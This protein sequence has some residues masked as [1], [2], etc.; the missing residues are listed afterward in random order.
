[1]T[2]AR[3]LVFLSAC[4]AAACA[5]AALPCPVVAAPGS[6]PPAVPGAPPAAN[7][8]PAEGVT[9]L[10][11]PAMSPERIVHVELDL[12]P[13][14]QTAGQAAPGPWHLPHGSPSRI[15][16]ASARDVTGELTVATTAKGDG[17]DLVLA[18]P[19]SGAVHVAYDLL[20]G[21]DAPDDPLGALVQDDRFRA[22]GGAMLALPEA[23]ASVSMPVRIRIDG[24]A[25]SAP[26]AASSFGVGNTRRVTMPLGGL[27][28]AVF[29][30]GSLGGQV[31]DDPGAGHDEAA[32]LGYTAFDPRTATAELAQ[33][34]SALH[35]LF[36]EQPGDAWT[37]L[38]VSQT[39]PVGSFS[40]TPRWMSTLLQVG[41]AEPWS[42]ALR[43][44]MTQQLARRWIGGQLAVSTPE[45]LESEGLWFSDGVSRY[46]ATAL[47]V[48]LGL[49]SPDDMQQAIAGELSVL[50]TS[51]YRSH[52]NAKL[53]KLTTTDP[54]ARATLMARGALYAL[55]ESAQLRARSKGKAG[56]LDALVKM[57]KRSEETKARGF[58][59]ADWLA[60][61]GQDD[62]DAARTFEAYVDRGDA[63]TLPPDALGPCFRPGTGE[64]V[65]YDAGFDV[66][67]TRMSS[68]GK[69]VGLRPA[70]PAA[71]AGLAEGD[72]VESMRTKEGFADA[73]VQLAVLRKGTKISISYVPRGAH[74]RGQTWTRVPGIR[75]AQCGELL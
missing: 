41:P 13:Q 70:G 32:W 18:R 58:S 44:S 1:M 75:D 47:L 36:K 51:P 35:E 71:K 61:L 33:I 2:L 60:T 69:V 45:G 48:R 17:V 57:R 22:S 72:E 42:S 50:A 5:P 12:V 9:V 7:A 43:L 34:R 26:G 30:A 59:V 64:Y 21:G 15:A 25:L 65:A 31:M 11:R 74:G 66:E 46:L 63:V 39:R 37:Y 10:L 54:V 52:D 6:P 29:M 3:G 40:T 24:S 68:D 55:R 67:A 4:L 19:T 20:A 16:R 14:G 62:P 73:P 56:L 49:L 23:L 38:V 28:Y 53:A 8:P 27:T